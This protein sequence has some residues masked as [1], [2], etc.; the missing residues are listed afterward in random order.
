[1]M[2]WPWHVLRSAPS[3]CT[4]R[5]SF[6]L[7][8]RHALLTNNVYQT[9]ACG[10]PDVIRKL[11][12][13][14]LHYA[15]TQHSCVI[16]HRCQLAKWANDAERRDAAPTHYARNFQTLPGKLPTEKSLLRLLIQKKSI[17]FLQLV[18]ASAGRFLL[19]YKSLSVLI[20]ARDTQ[21]EV[22]KY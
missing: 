13:A 16:W 22:F 2:I 18:F 20:N 19:S 7:R 5:F 12:S 3:L 6:K 9:D 17:A 8:P 14:Q 4:E 1:M 10:R 21:S 11:S 15:G